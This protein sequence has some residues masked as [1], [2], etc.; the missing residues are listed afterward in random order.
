V[1]ITAIRSI[2]YAYE[3]TRP[4]GD[5]NPPTAGTR[6]AADLAVFVETD[7]GLTG[8][9]I[10]YAQAHA[11][12][13]A[14]AA[15]LI[16]E[17]PRAVRALWQRMME[18]TFKEGYGGPARLALCAI[19]CALWDLRAK[20]NGVP[21]WKEL[22]GL[23]DR[24]PAYA[25]GVDTP[26]D[27]DALRSFYERMAGMGV[28]A[29]KLKVGRD[30]EEDRRRLKVVAEALGRS[31]KAAE[32]IIDANEYWSVKQA[33]QRIADLERDFEFVWVEEP[34]R[35]RD[36]MGLRRV[37]DAVRAPVATGENL[38]A[39]AEF[40]PLIAAGA[41]DVVQIAASTNGITGALQTAELAYAN[42]LPVSMMNCPGRFMAHLAAALPNHTLMEVFDAGREAM[43]HE[44]PQVADGQIVLGDRPGS[45]IEFDDERL[46]KGHEAFKGLS[47][48]LDE[49]YRRAS[50]A[51]LVGG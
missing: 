7:E 47:I 38:S 37:S 34:V 30:R 8:T 22:G 39:A 24:V 14:L 19:D 11:H 2:P 45:G 20:A 12:I 26:L 44:Q 36:Q 21:L 27:D 29:G 49:T 31:G 32:L 51:G 3:F 35:R 5:V 10:G 42:D 18:L 1:K 40:V 17:D 48:P 28:S 41:V 4:L 46:R 6:L 23:R 43:L 33:I 50:D 15:H 9:T 25:S 16:G 13:D